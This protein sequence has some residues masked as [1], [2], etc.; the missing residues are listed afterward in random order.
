MAK[1]RKSRIAKQRERLELRGREVSQNE[2]SLEDHFDP[3]APNKEFPAAMDVAIWSKKQF[4]IAVDHKYSGTMMGFISLLL[5]NF[6]TLSGRIHNRKVSEVADILGCGPHWVYDLIRRANESGIADLKLKGKKIK[7]Y[8][9]HIAK[10]DDDT[11]MDL[12]DSHA[13]NSAMI[14]KHGI[15][16]LIENKASGSDFRLAI[17]MALN[18]N[19]RT[20]EIHEMRP[21]DWA[22]LI[23]IHRTT[24]NRGLDNLNEIGV[25]QTK[26]DYDVTG[27]IPYTAAARAYFELKFREKLYNDVYTEEK[28]K[29]CLA[30]AKRL[31]YQAYG[32]PLEVMSTTAA[33]KKF[34][35]GLDPEG[36]H[37]PNLKENSGMQQIGKFLQTQRA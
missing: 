25:V 18:C 8:L 31:L 24:A 32:I 33:V 14:H 37:V 12:I 34:Y 28:G 23:G 16:A 9:K 5:L 6:N 17:A 29:S 13:L 7:G 11:I 10:S 2:D 36:K 19:L 35:S 20:G 21:S 1:Q 22:A 3:L 30:Q 4:Q 26:T 15:Q 27:R